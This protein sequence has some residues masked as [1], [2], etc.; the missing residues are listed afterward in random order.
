[1][2]KRD[3]IAF[4]LVIFS[5]LIYIFLCAR[6][7][8]ILVKV[9][10]S[11]FIPDTYELK[12]DSLIT[13]AIKICS[14]AQRYYHKSRIEA[15]GGNSFRGFSIPSYLDT[16]NYGIFQVSIQNKLIKVLA[17]GKVVGCDNNRP[18]EVELIAS[19][20]N[21]LVTTIHN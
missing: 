20:D 4:L 2:N 6:P 7:D 9:R 17:I 18:M 11:A 16:T 1:M 8:Y 14:I 5:F 10:K 19:P 15:G 13:G 12:R 3:F 21:I